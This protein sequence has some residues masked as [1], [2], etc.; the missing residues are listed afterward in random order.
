MAGFRW[1]HVGVAALLSAAAVT[2]VGVVQQ[3][4]A[5]GGG[6]GGAVS[7]LTPITPCR[8]ADTR[9]EATVGVRA[10]PI[11]PGES[12]TFTVWGSN[13]QCT[14][15]STATGVSANVTAVGSTAGGYLTLFPSDAPRP[16]AS[17]L[18]F[19]AGSPPIP[20]AVTVRLSADGKL[21]VYNFAG[22][23]DVIIDLA[24][25]Y[26][27]TP[28]G[29][30]GPPGAAGP[31]GPAGPAGQVG[32][33][34][35]RPIASAT[36]FDSV[37][38]RG[39]HTAITIGADGNPVISYYSPSGLEATVA[40]CSNPACTSATMTT[41]DN[42]NSS[43]AGQFTSV[44]IG[45]N[46]N[47][48]ISNYQPSGGDLKVVACINPTCTVAP[49]VT[50]LDTAGFVGLHT[51]ITIGANGNPIIS[52]WDNGQS[53]LKVAAC[54]NPACTT[55]TITPLDT[56]GDVGLYT[57]IAIGANGNPII[58]YYDNGN[59][60][61]KVA[62]CNNPACT[63]ATITS[64]DTAGFVGLYTSIAIGANGNPIISYYDNFNGALKVAACNNPACTSATITAVD[65]AGDVGQYTSIA[66]GAYGDPVISYYDATNGDLKVSTM[67]RTGWAPND[68]GR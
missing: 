39:Q 63:S 12:V 2:F 4:G 17:N 50:P 8:L 9:A 51:A 19:V 30:A 1:V 58:S 31:A 27:P 10:T 54:S 11:G 62:A 18:N 32:P 22:S 16:L 42:G 23:V 25:Y 13:G 35:G 46:G 57:S 28:A 67:R 49:T 44:T 33:Q 52:Y 5:S 59:A 40:A 36:R 29:P 15:P 38:N 65:T 37:G 3:A 55:A 47:P 64:V 48:I 53:D 60:D 21:N 34:Y 41:V 66:I 14:I 26:S 7:S 45:S 61:L 56:G 6:G 68:W 20:N 43:H 24:G